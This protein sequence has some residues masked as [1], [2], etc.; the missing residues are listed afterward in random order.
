M[1]KIPQRDP[2]FENTYVPRRASREEEWNSRMERELQETT[3]YRKVEADQRT[4][5]KFRRDRLAE[6]HLTEKAPAEKQY[7]VSQAAEAQRNA[8][9]TEKA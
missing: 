5:R 6:I 9:K 7:I 3:M 4:Q 2:E 1:T 8:L